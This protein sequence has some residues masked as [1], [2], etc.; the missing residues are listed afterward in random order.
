MPALAEVFK[1]REAPVS[2][3]SG[4]RFKREFGFDTLHD[5]NDLDAEDMKGELQRVAGGSKS[6]KS[7]VDVDPN[8]PGGGNPSWFV[9]TDDPKD[10]DAVEDWLADNGVFWTDE[11]GETWETDPGGNYWTH[12][13]RGQTRGPDALRAAGKPPAP[14][15][16]EDF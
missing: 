12:H 4:H 15:E 16:V 8:G 5:P 10:G 6:G 7:E 2:H 9:G 1:I 13:P 11:D 3:H 14:D